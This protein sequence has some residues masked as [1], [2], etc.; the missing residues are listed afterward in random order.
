MMRL[1]V[2]S[3][4]LTE[5]NFVTQ[6]LRPHLEQRSSG[7]IAVDAPRLGGHYT[8]AKLRRFVKRLLGS[9]TAA[10]LVSTMIDLYGVARD[11]PGLGEPEN[12]APPLDRVRHLE[13]CCQQDIN[14]PR[15][16]PY[17]QLHEFEALLL[18]NI[19][20]LVERYPN[21]RTELRELAGRLRGIAPEDV[22]R[23][24][25]PSHRIRQVVPE[26]S[27]AVDGVVTVDRIGL[28]VIRRR[29]LHFGQWLDQ[30]ETLRVQI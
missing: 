13:S 28:E 23:L 4:G 26:Y 15:F 3:E 10:V 18:P 6:I 9:P 21:R 29:C 17:L 30:L 11:F 5:F 14:D 27:K 20:L 8:Y 24:T 12:D 22:N 16:I 2:V 7:P 19:E 1:Y 25:P